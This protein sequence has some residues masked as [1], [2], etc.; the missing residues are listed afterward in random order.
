VYYRLS[1]KLGIETL[2]IQSNER[3]DFMIGDDESINV[4]YLQNAP[5][6]DKNI[7]RF[8]DGKKKTNSIYG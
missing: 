6:L 5:I 7:K 1:Q 3:K 2:L 8:D 4:F